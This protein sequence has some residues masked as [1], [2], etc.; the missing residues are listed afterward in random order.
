MEFEF[1]TDGIMFEM[2]INI[3]CENMTLLS[4]VLVF[5]CYMMKMYWQYGAV[6]QAAAMRQYFR[7]YNDPSNAI[8]D[9][10]RNAAKFKQFQ[11]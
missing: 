8:T 7:H 4:S 5:R 9:I 11:V 2:Q 10:A 1:R 3:F 6:S